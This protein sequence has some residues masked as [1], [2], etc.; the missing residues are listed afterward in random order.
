MWKGTEVKKKGKLTHDEIKRKLIKPLVMNNTIEIDDF[1]KKVEEAEDPERAA[2]VIQEC[3]IIIR[4]KKKR[5]NSDRKSS[6]QGF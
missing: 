1:N 6:R 3:E 4:T 5:H 2:E